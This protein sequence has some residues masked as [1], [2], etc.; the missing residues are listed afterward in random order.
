[1]KKIWILLIAIIILLLSIVFFFVFNSWLGYNHDKWGNFGSYIGG[2]GGI[3]LSCSLFY[4]TYTVDKDHKRSEKNTQ[5]L[6]LIEVVGESLEFYQRWQDLNVNLYN[7]K[8]GLDEHER[9]VSER[10]QLQIKLWTNYKTT[11]VLA[12]NL[13]DMDIPYVRELHETEE[14]FYK[15]FNRIKE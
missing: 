10:N 14:F 11:Q 3:V 13:Y 6:K 7:E 9:M 15:V 12:K 2:I 5:A 4:Y 8:L 1:M